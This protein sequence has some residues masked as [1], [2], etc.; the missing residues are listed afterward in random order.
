MSISPLYVPA[1]T[2]IA[3]SFVLEVALLNASLTALLI[4][5]SDLVTVVLVMVTCGSCVSVDPSGASGTAGSDA[6][7]LTSAPTVFTFA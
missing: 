1:A 3:I 4:A 6:S 7:T 5:F 2:V